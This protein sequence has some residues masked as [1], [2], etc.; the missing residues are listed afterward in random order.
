M[1]YVIIL[2][3]GEARMLSELNTVP[4]APKLNRAVLGIKRKI[5]RQ[6]ERRA[7]TPEQAVMVEHA[8]K[9]MTSDD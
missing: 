6:L 9:E 4:G 2:T 3:P 1:K 5:V 8:V 7:L